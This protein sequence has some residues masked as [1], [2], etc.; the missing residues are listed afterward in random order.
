[1][2][3]KMRHWTEEQKTAF[4]TIAD[5]CEKRGRINYEKAEKD[6][7]QEWS[8]ITSTRSRKQIWQYWSRLKRIRKTMAVTRRKI[9]TPIIEVQ[10]VP[11]LALCP[12][13]AANLYLIK[14]ALGGKEVHRC[15]GCNA[16]L[17]AVKHAINMD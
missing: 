1:M 9:E 15:P 17:R 3:K 7:P 11:S 5:G 16:N 10:E 14:I 2:S 4:N 13:C 8:L 12:R 6:F